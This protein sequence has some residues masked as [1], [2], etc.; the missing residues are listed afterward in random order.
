MMQMPNTQPDYRALCA[1]LLQ[2][3]CTHYRSWELKEGQCS[4]AMQR[5]RTALAAEQQG[6]DHAPISTEELRAA[7]NQQADEFNQWE[8][9]DLGE[10]LAWA[11]AR[12]IA[13]YGRHP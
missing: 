9:L 12:A 3:L 13:R 10:Q 6:P 7:W 1:E 5:A 4:D 8:S 2:E 11:Q